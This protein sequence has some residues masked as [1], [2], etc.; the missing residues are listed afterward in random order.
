[1]VTTKTAI[2]PT[3]AFLSG[4]NNN[5]S[6]K[7]PNTPQKITPVI[8]E[9]AKLIPKGENLSRNRTLLGWILL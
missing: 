6:N 4:L 1:M 2:F 7:A 9:I 8:A 5:S 3:S